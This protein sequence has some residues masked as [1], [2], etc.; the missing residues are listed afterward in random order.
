MTISS[1]ENLNI[2]ETINTTLR[3]YYHFDLAS[4]E[5]IPISDIFNQATFYDDLSGLSDCLEAKLHADDISS[6]EL[7]LIET[8]WNI[9]ASILLSTPQ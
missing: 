8:L 4:M 6:G 7:R 3:F 9:R 5:C 1:A 2:V